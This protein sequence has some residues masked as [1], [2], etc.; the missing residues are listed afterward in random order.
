MVWWQHQTIFVYFR[1]HP[2]N[3]NI[4]KT[5][6]SLHLPKCSKGH[7]GSF[8]RLTA[9]DIAIPKDSRTHKA[10]GGYFRLKSRFVAWCMRIHLRSKTKFHLKT[11]SPQ[12]S[13][14]QVFFRRASTATAGIPLYFKGA[15]RSCVGKDRFKPLWVRPSFGIPKDPFKPLW[16][17]LSFGINALIR[18][19]LEW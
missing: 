17:R 3:N 10:C 4:Y 13:L 18:F 7:L 19:I 11:I 9:S 8:I 15:V 5:K 6:T 12:G 14:K 1:K 16:V 2:E